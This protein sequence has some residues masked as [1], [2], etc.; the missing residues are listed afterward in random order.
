MACA[1]MIILSEMEGTGGLAVESVEMGAPRHLAARFAIS[2]MHPQSRFV[3]TWC[4][5]WAKARSS[6]SS[7][8]VRE[9]QKSSADVL[10]VCDS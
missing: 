4:G 2:C 8:G 5:I 9:N 10:A 7:L 1:R 6:Y 3:I